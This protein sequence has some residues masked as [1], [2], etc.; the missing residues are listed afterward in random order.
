[1][2]QFG[3]YEAES[4]A[5]AAAAQFRAAVEAER[6]VARTREA[7]AERAA[8]DAEE[9]HAAALE[10]ERR[11]AAE[12]V[13][14]ERRAGDERVAEAVEAERRASAAALERARKASDEERR[15]AEAARSAACARVKEEAARAKEA[16]SERDGAAAMADALCA[17]KKALEA[18]LAAKEAV[19]QD[20]LATMEK[21]RE[22][23]RNLSREYVRVAMAPVALE[24]ER[25]YVRNKMGALLDAAIH[26]DAPRILRLLD[27]YYT[28][29]EE[30]AC[31]DAW[32][33]AAEAKAYEASCELADEQ[34][35]PRLKQEEFARVVR[36]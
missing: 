8:A 14:A 29:D 28:T 31:V 27:A 19:V 12:A 30:T 21:L 5:A 22:N 18:E 16:R 3:T 33:R 32:L 15:A 6:R 25:E 17:A 9:A 24:G 4:K 23:G 34:R 2:F 35:M 26:C 11:V 10:C 20:L 7:A 36:R 1:M 13:A